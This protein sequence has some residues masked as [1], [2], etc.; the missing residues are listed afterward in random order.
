M[1]LRKLLLL[2]VM[3]GIG[4]SISI[5]TPTQLLAANPVL[6]EHNG[7]TTAT[8]QGL[9]LN[10]QSDSTLVL[11]TYSPTGTYTIQP[12]YAVQVPADPNSTYQI[13]AAPNGIRST[14]T[15][16]APSVTVAE[17]T[18][19]LSY[20]ATPLAVT[21]TAQP[22]VTSSSSEFLVDDDGSIYTTNNMVR[23]V[24]GKR[25]YVVGA[26]LVPY[27][28]SERPS[29]FEVDLVYD[30]SNQTF[31]QMALS[32]TSA[33]DH[34]VFNPPYPIPVNTAIDG[35]AKMPFPSNKGNTQIIQLVIRYYI[36]Q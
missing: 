28:L 9:Q 33:A 1:F 14:T 2:G 3:V 18:T 8:A 19:P 7:Q 35:N 29:Q 10:N 22:I 36:A 16:P 12:N 27:V 23:A 6:P 4:A 24:P 21:T 30:G 32:D 15:S 31:A 25:I 17:S 11:T 13:D 34:I 26:D 5:Y 20:Q